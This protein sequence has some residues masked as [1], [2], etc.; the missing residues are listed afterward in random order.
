VVDQSGRRAIVYYALR[1]AKSDGVLAP[2]E[3]DAIK[4]LAKQ[5]EVGEDLVEQLNALVDTEEQSKALRMALLAP[6]K[7]PF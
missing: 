4:A 5:L 1:A 3:M 2:R 7:R 6:G